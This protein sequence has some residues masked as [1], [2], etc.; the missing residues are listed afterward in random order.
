LRRGGWGE[1]VEERGVRRGGW[2]EGVEERWADASEGIINSSSTHKELVITAQ[3]S[4]YY[5]L[6][7]NGRVCLKIDLNKMK[8]L[9]HL[10]TIHTCVQLDII[11]YSYQ[12]SELVFSQK[13]LQSPNCVER[14]LML[15]KYEACVIKTVLYYNKFAAYI[16][17]HYVYT[18]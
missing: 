5:I 15:L 9:E 18:S 6:S 16:P 2:G 11:W 4:L 7:D 14:V 10:P 12:P 13:N 17:T 8:R 1:G 3:T